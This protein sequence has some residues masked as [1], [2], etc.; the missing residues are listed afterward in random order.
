MHYRQIKTQFQDLTKFYLF[1]F[2]LVL[3]RAKLACYR[4]NKL[5][6]HLLVMFLFHFMDRRFGSICRIYFLDD[7]QKLN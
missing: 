3:F 6:F 5:F 7:L 1:W 2:V 4:L